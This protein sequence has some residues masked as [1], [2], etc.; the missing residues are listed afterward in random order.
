[1]TGRKHVN[2][3]HISN[4][5]VSRPKKQ[6]VSP[7]RR[8]SHDTSYRKFSDEDRDYLDWLRARA[9]DFPLLFLM[10]DEA[11]RSANTVAPSPKRTASMDR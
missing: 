3:D 5:S 4:R 7:K 9:R 1:M 2:L 8:L 10:P 11:P 6:V